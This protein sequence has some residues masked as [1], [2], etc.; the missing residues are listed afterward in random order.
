MVN[1]MKTRK[2]IKVLKLKHGAQHMRPAFNDWN[3]R[4]TWSP[5]L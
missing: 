2:N 1:I 3:T 5:R 4:L